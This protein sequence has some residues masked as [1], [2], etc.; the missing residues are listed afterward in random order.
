MSQRYWTDLPE[1]QRSAWLAILDKPSWRAQIT[2]KTALYKRI[3]MEGL[4]AK[5]SIDETLRT[6]T[7]DVATE[8]YARQMYETQR[9]AG[10]G[11]GFDLPNTHQADTMAK[12]IANL[13]YQ[14]ITIYLEM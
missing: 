12:N 1:P 10:V 6:T 13:R 3:E 4:T 11:W 7:A 2:N 14:I 5:R 9:G 8:G